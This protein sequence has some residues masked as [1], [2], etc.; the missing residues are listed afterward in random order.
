[1]S[2]TTLILVVV[3]KKPW[4][5]ARFINTELIVKLLING[6][7]RKV[8]FILPEYNPGPIMYSINHGNLAIFSDILRFFSTISLS[9]TRIIYKIRIL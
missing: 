1:M 7:V 2:G 6:G 4:C 9:I 3:N 5:S 8:R